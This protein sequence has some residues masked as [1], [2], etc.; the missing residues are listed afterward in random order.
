MKF[1]NKEAKAKILNKIEAKILILKKRFLKSTCEIFVL[2]QI[3]R[4]HWYSADFLLFLSLKIGACQI[5]I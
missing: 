1:L 2:C 4:N 3:D 5:R